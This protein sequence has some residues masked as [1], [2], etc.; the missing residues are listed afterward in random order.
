MKFEIQKGNSITVKEWKGNRV[1][2]MIDVD[3]LHGKVNGKAYRNF[4]N[5]RR[6][7]AESVD[8]YK[9]SCN[10]VRQLISDTVRADG[11]KA[12]YPRGAVLLTESGYMLLVKSFRDKLSVEIQKKVIDEYFHSPKRNE[13]CET[14]TARAKIEPTAEIAPTAEIPPMPN[15]SYERLLGKYEQLLDR[16]AKALEEERKRCDEIRDMMRAEV[17]RNEE[18]RTIMLKVLETVIE[19]SRIETSKVETADSPEETEIRKTPLATPSEYTVWKREINRRVDE[20]VETGKY[21]DRNEVLRTAYDALRN[22]Y[23]ICFEQYGKEFYRDYGRKATNTMELMH[24][25]ETQ[26]RVC[27][28]LL[29]SKLVNM[30]HESRAKK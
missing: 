1:L 30:L 6:K 13:I 25:I 11:K 24:Y 10:E 15:V 7:F 8:Y 17:K 14:E 9:V 3:T 21:A 5:N 16:Q 20:I 19:T 23:G 2:T 18:F 12:N 28:N 22:E 4:Q 26:N 27:K 29:L